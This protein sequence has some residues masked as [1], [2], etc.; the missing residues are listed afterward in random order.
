MAANPDVTTNH[1]F[2]LPGSHAFGVTQ[3]FSDRVDV[4]YQAITAARKAAQALVSHY[5]RIQAPP[6]RVETVCIAFPVV[7]VKAPIFNC[8]FSSDGILAT[9][10]VKYQVVLRTGFDTFYSA[11]EIVT[12]SALGS[13]ID[14]KAE[15]VAKFLKRLPNRIP[16]TLER[17]DIG[18][19]MSDD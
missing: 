13:F 15:L 18:N 8:T 5:D 1:L 11:V 16:G 2:E 7:V 12:E 17:L 9:Q 6:N 4:P 14:Q 3:A 19:L 10:E